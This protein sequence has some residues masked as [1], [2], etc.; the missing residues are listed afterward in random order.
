[1]RGFA[2]RA[3]R[4][5]TIIVGLGVLAAYS[6]GDAT[7]WTP[8]A[9]ADS[10]GTS[11]NP[12]F[13]EN[14]CH[15][16]SNGNM[17]A[18]VVGAT[19]RATWDVT[20]AGDPNLQG[21]ATDISV[22]AGDVVHFK[23]TADAPYHFDIYRL[24]YY[25]GNGARHIDGPLA[26][27]A[28][29]ASQ[30][31]L[32]ADAATGLVD[33]GNWSES[34]SWT[35][36]ATAV[37]GIYFA[38]LSRDSDSGA[39]HIF[40]VVRNDASHSDLLVQTSDTTWQAY[41]RYGGNS[42]YFG[43]PAPNPPSYEGASAGRA[44]K[45]SYNR[46]FDTR[47]HDPQSF[48]FNAEYPM[49]KWLEANGYNISYMAGV[50]TD[51]RGSLLTQHKVFLSSGH[52][53]YWSATQRAN[54]EAA[55]NA[56]VNLAFFSGNESF[57]KTRWENS[58]VDGTDHRT[59]VSYKETFS[60]INAG[61]QDPS[62]TEAT[63][64]WRDPRFGAPLDGGRPE[65]GLTGTI[66]TVND[67]STSLVVPAAD[68]KMR[69]WRGTNL[70]ATALADGDPARTLPA[71]TVGYE[72]DEDLDNG[73]RPAG[74]FHLSTTSVSVPERIIDYGANF[75][76]AVATHHLTMYRHKTYDANGTT[77]LSSALVFGAGTVQWSWGLDS[78]HD[79]G[80]SVTDTRMQQATVNLLADMGAQP[81]SLQTGLSAATASTDSDAPTSMVTS[82]GTATAGLPVT[83][84][85]TATDFGGGV[86]GGVEVS[87]DGG[88]TWHPA[89]GRESWTYSWTPTASG[90]V[91]VMS[92]A[93]DDSGNIET[94][95][96]A[97]FAAAS[98]AGFGTPVCPCSIFAPAAVPLHD[99]DPD[100][101]SIDV[102]VKFR[103][104][105]DGFITA[106]RFYR[107]S[108]ITDP[109]HVGYLWTS[110]GALLGTATF[111][112]ETVIGW[113]EAPLD[114]PVAVTAG[115][116]YVAS[117]HA[118]GHYAADPGY[119][120]TKGE[121]RFPLHAPQDGVTGGD[122]V[123]TY[124]GGFPNQTF[125]SANY[126]MDVV[127]NTS[128]PPLTISDVVAIPTS[129]VGTAIITWTTNRS[130]NSQVH[131]GVTP[132]DLTSSTPIDSALVKQ[133]RVTLTG[134][135]PSHTYYFSVTSGAGTA[136]TASDGPYH[137]DMPT[138]LFV[139]TT[140]GDFSA[141]T[142]GTGTY[143]GDAGDGEV[144]LA[145]AAGTEFFDT[146]LPAGWTGSQWNPGQ[147]VL[148]ITGGA[149][150]VDG[151]KINTVD[152][153]G[154]GRSLEFAT[155]FR[156][157]AYQASGF[158]VDFNDAPWIIFGTRGSGTQLYA[159]T[160]VG[161]SLIE[162][163]LSGVYL[164]TEHHYRIV[165]TTAS[166]Q[167]FVDDVPVATHSA[168]L[169]TPMHAFA[170]SDYNVN[171]I[172]ET[173]DWM[174]M[175]AYAASG[176]FESRVFDAGSPV[177]WTVLPSSTTT[178]GL[179]AITFQTRTSA[180]KVAWSSWT[181]VSNRTIASPPNQYLQ[182]RATLATPDD[183]VT[184]ILEQVSV[185]YN[186]AATTTP[187]ITWTPSGLIYGV[188]IGAS[189]L[190]A[191]ASVG[192]TFA[193][194]ENGHALTTGAILDAGAHTLTAT[195]TPYD[196]AGYT[197]ATAS[198]TISVSPA[199]LT[200]TADN[201]T[202]QYGTPNPAFTGTVSGVLNGDGISAT[203]TS[204][205]TPT[206]PVGTYPITASLNDPNSRLGNYTVTI[207]AGTLTVV[208]S[209]TSTSTPTSSA[210]PSTY[211]QSIT[212]TATVTA[213]GATPTGSVQFFD[214]ATSL[215]VVPLNGGTA[216]LTT[217]S[218][219]AG[220]RSITA[221]FLGS[222]GFMGS[223]SPSALAL[224]VN[225][226]SGT[227]A[228][229]VSALTPQYSDLDTFTATFT[230]TSGGPVPASVDF[231]VGTDV[232][233]S[234]PFTL[235]NGAWQAVWTGQLIERTAVGQMKPGTRIVTASISDTN[236][237]VTA[238][239]KAITIQKEDARVAYSGATTFS[240]HGSA[241]GTIP[242]TEIVKDITAM[243][244]DA[245][246]DNYPGDIRNAQV[247]VWDR[248]TNTVLG[249]VN[250]TV[251]GSDLTIGSATFNWNVNLGTATSK[252]YTLGFVVTNYYNRN[253]TADNVSVTVTK[254]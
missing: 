124:A 159:S 152:S 153:F 62:T 33:C 199:P 44:Y 10:C 67:G 99:A 195:F 164:N 220:T 93:V 108:G 78:D 178:P 141:G 231:K 244:G 146:V 165:W 48:V 126:W 31:C 24:G 147:G 254:N 19:A 251:S 125:G 91:T 189:Q 47:D 23:I 201:A 84:T 45:V 105:V 64:S 129:P 221:T 252:T 214:G 242:L 4:S 97:R 182:Y 216:S 95:A 107:G 185:G 102:G 118:N 81:T 200:V 236:F 72:W 22:N 215:G 229:S 50:D 198:R 150:N 70:A 3:V 16:D 80:S 88:A 131:Y 65:N 188:G 15:R 203:F 249:T 136:D 206:S 174:R 170:A 183:T 114:S 162:T 167:F 235:V 29:A 79:R 42:L 184:P 18:G 89:N 96:S 66:F 196:L 230:P 12:I 6:R 238:P 63:A 225:K 60:L 51:R 98:V 41:N 202:R 115:T 243:A 144:L 55:R 143:L 140:V 177:N 122:G 155:T 53:E 205:A 226:A 82:I 149:A 83:A 28:S 192:G 86:V 135:T 112:N 13:L 176:A 239:T 40:F 77:V 74:L 240:L 190:N 219:S 21:F 234:A 87:V 59:L 173:V 138:N 233:G 209:A 172:Y 223:S 103:A 14:N 132:T 38:R 246:W 168:A 36:P 133:H 113:Q 109:T 217:A 187:T 1:M 27:S 57:W 241:T 54:V 128:L 92:R 117:Y 253:Q 160:F 90:P 142:F 175:S 5:A 158:G 37:S 116:T 145:P 228:L 111:N 171:G 7:P 2:K 139:D 224:T 148:N 94:P 154:P 191:A 232:A 30:T 68:G 100:Q 169:S 49:V 222:V 17:I 123:Y 137:F 194:S 207:N 43:G 127:F 210:N 110:A 134:L 52:D 245:A 120:A 8:V 34:A 11:T 101:Q 227:T 181:A 218:I 212:L 61:V 204:A 85:G 119:F 156:S 163:P 71:N 250:V 211:G 166:T 193:Y 237:S 26:P 197:T 151:Y 69:F 130:T 25:G 56:G 157:D 106:L 179:S 39:S 9:A 76:P 161:G 46:P 104:D 32:P 186:T 248:G 20:G 213:N 180:D 208:G 58:I 75:G 121:D 247:Q 35:V 73:A